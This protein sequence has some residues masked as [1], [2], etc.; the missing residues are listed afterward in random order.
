MRRR[1]FIAGLGSTP[2]Y[3][4]NPTKRHSISGAHCAH[5]LDPGYIPDPE[6]A[7]VAE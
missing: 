3:L 2:V 4:G 7:D 5:L 1:E 6:R